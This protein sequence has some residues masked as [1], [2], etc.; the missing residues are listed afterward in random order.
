MT[1][2]L[3]RGRKVFEAAMKVL[4]GE[5]LQ[6]AQTFLLV[7]W[8]A[9]Q[10]DKEPAGYEAMLCRHHREAVW[11]RHSIVTGCGQFGDSCDL[12]EDRPPMRV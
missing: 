8:Q 1:S 3:K 12:C 10:P 4:Q 7:R 11:L 9:A 2:I 5:Q 6:G